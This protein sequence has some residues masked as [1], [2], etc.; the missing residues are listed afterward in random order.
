MHYEGPLCCKVTNSSVQNSAEKETCN[1]S[2]ETGLL[3]ATHFAFYDEKLGQIKS[4]SEMG[5]KYEV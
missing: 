4:F 1:C 2:V 3:T 5:N